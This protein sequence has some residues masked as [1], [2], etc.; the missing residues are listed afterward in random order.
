MIHPVMIGILVLCSTMVKGQL[1]SVTDWHLVKDEKGIQVFTAPVGS[2][3]RKYIKVSATLDG[4]L[5]SVE[6]L[7]RDIDSQ[8]AW[9][10]GTRKSYLVQKI[11]TRHLLYYNETNVPWPASNRDV[12]IRMKFEEDPERNMLVITQTAEPNAVLVNKG[13][14]RVSHLSGY[15]QFH[16]ENEGRFHVDYYL[17]IDP[18][19]SIPIWVVNLFIAKGPYE[20]FIKLRE[21]L[22]SG[23]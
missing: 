16:K 10:Y 20:T 6:K 12:V 19:G 1:L 14:V 11:D 18:A 22:R 4:S 2:S 21:Q 13:I 23:G 7:F 5:Q 15:W 9:V 8:K 17:D 3:S